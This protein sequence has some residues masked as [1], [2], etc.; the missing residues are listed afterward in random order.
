MRL[1]LRREFYGVHGIEIQRG[2]KEPH[3]EQDHD[4]GDRH[5]FGHVHPIG[6]A[7]NTSADL[8]VGRDGDVAAVE[9]QNRHEVDEAEK[10]V[11]RGEQR[12]NASP[13]RLFTELGT[14]VHDA[15]KRHR[16]IDI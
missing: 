13:S 5:E 15:K 1:G 2:R 4:V 14:D 10:N 12:K 8:F 3:H 11:D 9:R 7:G 6:L 16:T